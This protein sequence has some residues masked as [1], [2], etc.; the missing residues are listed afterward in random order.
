[1]TAMILSSD[2]PIPAMT[3]FRSVHHPGDAPLALVVARAQARPVA[4][5]LVAVMVAATA[6]VLSGADVLGLVAWALPLA[7][8]GAAAWALF[9][10]RR[11]PAEILLRGPLGAVRSV[12]AV[13][14]ERETGVEEDALVP[15][16]APRKTDGALLV[17]FGDAAVALRPFEWPEFDRLRD[18][19]D[20]AAEAF[21]GP[22][23][24]PNPI[25]LQAPQ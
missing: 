9:E 3:R 19:L 24:A 15:V 10:L 21:A 1:M 2:D 23:S 22:T 8:A 7:Y 11:L 13:A 16:I 25:T 5:A 12:W 18:A 20:S 4:A 6:R 14:R 17:G